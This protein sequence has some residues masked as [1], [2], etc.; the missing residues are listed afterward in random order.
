VR[1]AAQLLGQLGLADAPVEYVQLGGQLGQALVVRPSR[2][3]VGALG[4]PLVPGRA[5]DGAEQGALDEV[6]D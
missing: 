1:G 4:R 3:A 6:L 2:V 5:L